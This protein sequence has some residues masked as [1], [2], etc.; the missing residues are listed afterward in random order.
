MTALVMEGMKTAGATAC[1]DKP[2]VV[3][4][5]GVSESRGPRMGSDLWSRIKRI[6]GQAPVLF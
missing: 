2:A 5:R 3:G 1:R 6:S 4:E